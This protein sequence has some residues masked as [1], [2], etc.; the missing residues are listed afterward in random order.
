MTLFELTGKMRELADLLENAEE[1][2]DELVRYLQDTEHALEEKVDNYCHLI[3]NLD[4]LAKAKKEQA[5][6]FA[7]QSKQLANKVDWL[8]GRLKLFLISIG[9]DKYETVSHKV[10]IRNSGGKFGKYEILPSG[11]LEDIPVEFIKE[12][13]E[14]SLDKEA[15]LA[16][17]KDNDNPP[18]GVIIK[19]REKYISI[20]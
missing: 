6:K 4:A 12:K 19:E 13:R 11:P 9:Q 15:V 18:T 5:D 8:K 10:A 1:M 7:S 2:P 17:I 16:Y 3:A 14:L 20:S